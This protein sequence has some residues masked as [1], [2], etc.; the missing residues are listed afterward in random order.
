MGLPQFKLVVRLNDRCVTSLPLGKP[1]FKNKILGVSS[2]QS[3][4]LVDVAVY[5]FFIIQFVDL[6]FAVYFFNHERDVLLEYGVHHDH[7]CN[8]TNLPH[9]AEQWVKTGGGICKL[10]FRNTKET[11]RCLCAL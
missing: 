6:S 3:K 4:R 5:F 11:V 10:N 7:H 9:F 8:Q 2:L 1:V